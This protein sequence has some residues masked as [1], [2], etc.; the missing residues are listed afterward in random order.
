M[1]IMK[2]KKIASMA[3]KGTNHSNLSE[4]FQGFEEL[5]DDSNLIT[6]GPMYHMPILNQP[7]VTETW[8]YVLEILAE[9][10]FPRRTLLSNVT[11]TRSLWNT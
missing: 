8:K 4:A 6:Q 2:W 11:I 3:A 9:Q 7:G 1:K 10:T 5:G